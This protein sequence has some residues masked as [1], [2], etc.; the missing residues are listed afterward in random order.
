MA[1][2]LIFTIP[3]EPVAKGRA[4]SLIRRGQVA[5][6][7]PQKTVHYENLVKLVAQQAM[8]GSAL[9][10]DAIA[11]TVR[12][13]LPIPISWSLKKQQLAV[14]GRLTPTKRPDI[15]NIIK[16]IKDGLTGWPGGMIHKWWK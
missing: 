7:T 14:L 10:E 16:S 8:A 2:P 11:L 9:L 13:F 12:A 4:R 1:K 6:Y 15:D 5:H 3:G